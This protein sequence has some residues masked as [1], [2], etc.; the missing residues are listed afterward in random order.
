MDD[1]IDRRSHWPIF[2]PVPM[3]LIKVVADTVRKAPVATVTSKD[4]LVVYFISKGGES[5]EKV[6]ER[7]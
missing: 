4:G 5:S 6:R 7:L 3:E 1:N 2:D